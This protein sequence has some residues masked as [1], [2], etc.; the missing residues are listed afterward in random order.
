MY[1]KMT[2]TMKQFTRYLPPQPR[3]CFL[4]TAPLLP[5]IPDSNELGLNL[6][7]LERHLTET[8]TLYASD[9]SSLR[10]VVCCF[11]AVGV[12]GALKWWSYSLLIFYV[13]LVRIFKNL[14]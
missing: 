14:E 12:W 10:C 6:I 2:D 3:L 4:R 8:V 1:S 9:V 13:S 11:A 5:D 7:I